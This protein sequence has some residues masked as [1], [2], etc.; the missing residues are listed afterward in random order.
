[1][2]E[3]SIKEDDNEA[4][5]SRM[6]LWKE[7]A[8]QELSAYYQEAATIRQHITGAKTGTK[9][10][11]YTKKM[12]AVQRDIVRLLTVINTIDSRMQKSTS[13]DA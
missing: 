1:M 10:R 2:E 12:G 7:A 3:H 9:K 13:A 11:Y 4:K 8:R 6:A 5:A